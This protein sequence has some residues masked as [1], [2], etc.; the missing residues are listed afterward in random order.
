MEQT[1][2]KKMNNAKNYEG[3]ENESIQ[4]VLNKCGLF[5]CRLYEIEHVSILQAYFIILILS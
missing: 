2:A 4:E 3:K 1:Q 5:P